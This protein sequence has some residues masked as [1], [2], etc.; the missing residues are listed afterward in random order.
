MISDEA[1]TKIF[2][3]GSGREEQFIRN[4]YDTVRAQQVFMYNCGTDIFNY[5]HHW[6]IE[7][8]GINRDYRLLKAILYSVESSKKQRLIPMGFILTGLP[9]TDLDVRYDKFKKANIRKVLRGKYDDRVLERNR[10]ANQLVSNPGWFKCETKDDKRLLAE[11]LWPGYG[12]KELNLT[13]RRAEQIE[14]SL[15]GGDVG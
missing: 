5:P 7:P 2:G 13:I 9:P 3:T 4:V 11:G 1:G 15:L 8:W 10:R 14:K 6:A 12:S